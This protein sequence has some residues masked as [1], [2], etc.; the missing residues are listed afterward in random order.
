MQAF[1][2]HGGMQYVTCGVLSHR[3]PS[4]VR[5]GNYLVVLH[6]AFTWMM[7]HVMTAVVG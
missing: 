1:E 6:D 7:Q 4:A 2:A 5:L 3:L